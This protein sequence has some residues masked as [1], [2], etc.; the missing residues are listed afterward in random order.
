MAGWC[1]RR[2]RDKAADC[3]M[4]GGTKNGPESGKLPP[5]TAPCEARGTRQ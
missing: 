4:R 2:G 3:L 1:L 5:A